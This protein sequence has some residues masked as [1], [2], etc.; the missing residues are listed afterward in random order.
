MVARKHVGTSL[1]TYKK[2][3]EHK[4][5]S[6]D[7]AL[8]TV[9]F[10]INGERGMVITPNAPFGVDRPLSFRMAVVDVIGEPVVNDEPQKTYFNTRHRPPKGH[11]IGPNDVCGVITYGHGFVL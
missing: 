7:P 1:R 11:Y 8:I 5:S 6:R 10:G 2:Q 9:E 4:H 3:P